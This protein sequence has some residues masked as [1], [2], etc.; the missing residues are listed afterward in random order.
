VP[1]VS[2]DFSA[3]P[4]VIRSTTEMSDAVRR[5]VARGELVALGHRLYTRAV[6]E[7]PAE[8][9]RRNVWRV[10]ALLVPGAV[11][12]DQTAFTTRPSD[13]SSVCVAAGR[14]RRTID[15]PGLR[16]R[17]RPGTPVEGDAEFMGMHLSSDARRYLDN[18]RNARERGGFRWTLPIEDVERRLDRF[19][20]QRGDEALNDLRDHARR[21]AGALDAAAEFDRLDQLI[22]ALLGTRKGPLRTPDARARAAGRPFDPNALR[23]LTALATRLNDD[24]PALRRPT[25]QT[26]GAAFAFWESY[27]SNYIEG[28]VF[29]IDVAHR[30]VFE[31][32]QPP[33]RSA[34]A[35]DITGTFELAND[36]A[37]TGRMAA[38]GDE[39]VD[40]L[41]EEHAV[42]MAGRPDKRPGQFKEDPNQAGNT[43]FVDPTLVRGTLRAGFDI[44]NNARPGL[45]RA[46]LMMFLVAETH[47][48][49]DGNGRTARLRMNA[50]LTAAGE[51]RIVI[52]TGFRTDYLGALRRLS[53]QDDPS[54]LI[55]A[56]DRAQA[57]SAEITWNVK[58]HLV[59]AQLERC[60]AFHEEEGRPLKLPSELAPLPLAPA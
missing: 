9:V 24:I 16:V 49:D 41:Q 48:F 42:L 8:V 23:R 20:A 11:V 13:D 18:L 54:V 37:R 27:F 29:A 52:P 6:D 38:D 10:V 17:V 22:G 57:F 21:I 5:A 32:Y 53:R 50:E 56:L 36:T 46:T 33:Q 34:D 43:L 35:H 7:A 15:L 51:Q 47:P 55:R 59:E 58:R 31:G 30:I 4:E 19:A 39:F 12:V 40:L 26:S 25:A 28:T 44:V 3:G 45:A 60:N 1:A 2:Y 14:R